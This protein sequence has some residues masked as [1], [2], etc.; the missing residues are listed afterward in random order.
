MLVYLALGTAGSLAPDLDSDRSAPVRVLFTLLSVAAAFLAL[1]L[2]SARYRTVAELALVWVATFLLF[3]WAVF[4]L[5][6]RVTRHRGIFHSVPAAMCCG[7]A[8]AALL[9]HLAGRSALQAWL[10]GGF[11]AFGYLMHL[12]LDELYS[13]NLFGSRARR[14]LGSA[15]KLWSARSGPATLA[16]YGLC[17]LALSMA[18]DP[19]PVYVEVS[20]RLARGANLDHWWPNAGWFAPT[21]AV[22]EPPAGAPI[23]LA[24]RVDALLDRLSTGFRRAQGP[25]PL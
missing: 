1:F 24:A 17:L 10:G 11:A 25:A 4:A 2:A 14:S 18:P 3:R 21:T 15:L 8:T 20:H 12:V 13:L 7:A 23:P 5:L 6:V 22:P 9:Y 19:R 16:A